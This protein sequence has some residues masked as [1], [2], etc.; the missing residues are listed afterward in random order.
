MGCDLA[1]GSSECATTTTVATAVTR[2]GD[3]MFFLLL[4]A[5]MLQALMLDLLLLP[6]AA[7]RR[8]RCWAKRPYGLRLSSSRMLCH[9]LRSLS[10]DSVKAHLHSCSLTN[11]EECGSSNILSTP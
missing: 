5:L 4:Q 7:T 2:R 9:P 1:D 8:R 6:V 11:V 3:R 10:D